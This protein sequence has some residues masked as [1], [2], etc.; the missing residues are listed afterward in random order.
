MPFKPKL[1]NPDER[2]DNLTS[3]NIPLPLDMLAPYDEILSR[4]IFKWYFK[5]LSLL[6]AVLANTVDLY[7]LHGVVRTNKQRTVFRVLILDLYHRYV[8]GNG[9]FSI[10]VFV[11]KTGA[12]AKSAKQ[13]EIIGAA[14]NV[15]GRI[16]KALETAEL[17]VI[18][19]KGNLGHSTK[20]SAGE[21]LIDLLEIENGFNPNIFKATKYASVVWVEEPDENDK[22]FVEKIPMDI[23]EAVRYGSEAIEEMNSI[24][25]ESSITFGDLPLFPSEKIYSRYIRKGTENSEEGYGRLHAPSW[26]RIDSFAREM[27]LING[28]K[29]AEID[30]CSCHP[31]IAYSYNNEDVTLSF[32]KGRKLYGI[33]AVNVSKKKYRKIVKLA[34]LCLLNAKNKAGAESALEKAI[35]VGK[36]R[37]LPKGVGPRDVIEELISKHVKINNWLFKKCWLRLTYIE[38]N[39]CLRVF[40]HFVRQGIPILSV[41]DSFVIQKDKK[42]ELEEL[43]IQSIMDECDFPFKYPKLLVETK[44]PESWVGKDDAEKALMALR[45]SEL[46]DN[47]IYGF[48]MTD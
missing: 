43:L 34:M 39:I 18:H 29:T 26:Q 27:I 23:D 36:L 6:N 30:I 31:A 37:K 38:S 3:S 47:M 40:E 25:E 16:V 1:H 41:H 13:G 17:L 33:E 15:L 45:R 7:S 46:A 44:E 32:E 2:S 4:P 5:D 9:L 19:K 14:G 42:N 48:E 11:S 35:R 10:G 24:L 21:I 28:K 12:G 20:I 8:E 22:G